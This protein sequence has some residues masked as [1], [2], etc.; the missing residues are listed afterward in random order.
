MKLEFRLLLL[1]LECF[2]LSLSPKT[3]A[4]KDSCSECDD[5]QEKHP[6]WLFCED[7]ETYQGNFNEWYESSQWLTESRFLGE[8]QISITDHEKFSGDYSLYMPAESGANY[9]GSE[10]CWYS[11]KSEKRMNCEL[12]G[13]DQL[14]L[15][16]YFK[17]AEDHEHVHHFINISGS[18]SDG[19][20]DSVGNAGCRP[21]GTL[22]A[23]TTVDYNDETQQSFFY[24]YSIDMH[25]DPGPV[26]DQ[27]NN[28]TEICERCTEKGMPCENGEECCWGNHYSADPPVEIPK[29]EWICFEMMM[30]LNDPGKKNGTMAYWING[31]LAHKQDSMFWITIPEIKLNRIALQHYNTAADANGHSN[32]IW[33]DNTV[34]STERIGCVQINP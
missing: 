13:Y 15:R 20:W 8:G 19:F 5:W 27:Y 6:E 33:W 10:L 12:K 1:F 25:C 18:K 7:F 21:S 16:T 2:L 24:T 3:F 23:R 28:A 9:E 11:C 14:F 34:V 30:K 4:Q 26:C 32:R 17:L 31:E 29:G 22:Y